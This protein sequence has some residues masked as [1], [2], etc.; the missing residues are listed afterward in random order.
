VA[1]ECGILRDVIWIIV[2]QSQAINR[3]EC[4]TLGPNLSTLTHVFLQVVRQH[5]AAELDRAIISSEL[6]SRTRHANLQTTK[7]WITK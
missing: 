4:K 2:N 5:A 6:G 7:S 1:T 3:P